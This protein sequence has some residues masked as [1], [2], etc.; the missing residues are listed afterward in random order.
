MEAYRF[1]YLS[2][3]ETD[4]INHI[5]PVVARQKALKKRFLL[6]PFVKGD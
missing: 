5:F 1:I 6:P 4:F 3:F 2:V